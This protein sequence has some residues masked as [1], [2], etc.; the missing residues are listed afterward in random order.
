MTH[1]DDLETKIWRWVDEVIVGE[2][3]C[4]F[5]KMPRENDR[6]KLTICHEKKMAEVLSSIASECKYLDEHPKVETSL[7]ACPNTLAK[8]D[9]YLDVLE[10]ANDLLE[11]IGYLG[12][13]QLA[14]FH[15]EYQFEGEAPQSISNY[16]NRSIVPIFHIIR[17]ASIT[18][19]LQFIKHP[20]EIPERNIAHAQAL[21][22]DFFKRYLK[23]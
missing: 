9:D 5:A 2:Q 8:F 19:A 6:I 14:S 18:Q 4:P 21:G 23:P 10:M 3:F 15:P 17:E 13:Y 20:E 22:L 7:I 12:V 1:N 11:D 16:T